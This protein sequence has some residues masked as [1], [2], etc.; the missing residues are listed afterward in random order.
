[1][2]SLNGLSRIASALR[3][4]TE[5][6]WLVVISGVTSVLFGVVLTFLPG[7]G[8]SGLVWVIGIYAIALGLAFIAYSYRLRG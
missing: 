7:A 4:Q 6:E 8:L 3:G 5:H 1:M 2:L